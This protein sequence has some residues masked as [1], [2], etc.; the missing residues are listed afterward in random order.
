MRYFAVVLGSVV[1][2]LAW[3]E[4]GIP[5]T[6]CDTNVSSC[7]CAATACTCGQVCTG[8]GCQASTAK[9]CSLD[10]DCAIGCGP[11][12]CAFDGCRVGPRP[13]GGTGTG[14]GT[15]ATGGGTAATGGGTAATGGGTAATGGG[16]AAT[17]GGTA[18]T[19][20]G[21]AATGGGTAAPDGGVTSTPQP[22]CNAAA[23]APGFGLLALS[24]AAAF[25]ARR[26]RH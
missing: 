21:T 9:F 17:G 14:G 23:S 8:G 24:L 3:A 4:A 12:H 25:R 22:G 15:A 16:T 11:T 19:G 7:T 20:G 6:L 18:A 5:F 26:R 1:S 13:D 10:S 2:S